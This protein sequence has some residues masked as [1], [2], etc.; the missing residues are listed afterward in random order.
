MALLLGALAAVALLVLFTTFD[1][2]CPDFEDEGQMAAPNSPYSQIMCDA[3]VTLEPVPMEQITVP[4]VLFISTAAALTVATLLVW[5]RPRLASRRVLVGG[6]IGVLIVQP[7]VIVALQYTLPRDCLSG[8]T[9]A[10]DCGRD[11]ELR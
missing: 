6:V 5:R 1:D 8:P 10:G 3:V 2:P 7:L 9:D 4:G 11:R